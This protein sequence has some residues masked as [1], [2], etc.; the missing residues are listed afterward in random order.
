M[1]F[2]FVAAWVWGVVDVLW[3]IFTGHVA[4]VL[5]GMQWSAECDKDYV[6]ADNGHKG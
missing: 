3:E 2:G 6:L 5:V 4:M 1:D